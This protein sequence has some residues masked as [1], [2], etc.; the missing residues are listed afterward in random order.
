MNHD[1][2]FGKYQNAQKA[3]AVAKEEYVDSVFQDI[4]GAFEGKTN[5]ALRSHVSK[6]LRESSHPPE[7]KQA[8][9]EHAHELIEEQIFTL[10]KNIREV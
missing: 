8:V 6:E 1:N 2:P 10:A 9:K 7:I 5:V 3:L 4:L